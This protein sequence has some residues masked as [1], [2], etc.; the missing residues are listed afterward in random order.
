P[1]FRSGTASGV[2]FMTLEDQT[3][4][5]NVVVWLAT[6]RA[7]NTPFVASKILKI[8]G[9]LEREGDVVHIIAGRLIDMTS[10]LDQLLIQAR[11]FH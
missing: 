3:G 2:T 1:L 4:N 7:Q 6:A 10:T 8:K 11:D 5:I 9:I